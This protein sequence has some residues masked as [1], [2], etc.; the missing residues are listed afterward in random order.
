MQGTSKRISF[1]YP[2][3]K[4]TRDHRAVHQTCSAPLSKFAGP[5]EGPLDSKH[6]EQSLPIP[7]SGRCFRNVGR[8]AN[9]PPMTARLDLS[10]KRLAAERRAALLTF[11]MAGDPD[12]ETSAAILAALPAAGADIV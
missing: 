7:P 2:P 6:G 1:I 12:S 5:V 11:I 8:R 9:D 3:D 10:F 4:R